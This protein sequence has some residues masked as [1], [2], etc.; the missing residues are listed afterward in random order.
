GFG[1]S[2]TADACT[3]ARIGRADGTATTISTPTPLQAHRWARVWVTWDATTSTI[4]VGQQA[5]ERGQ[6]VGP[7]E[8]ATGSYRG[9]PP[10]AP[11]QGLIGASEIDGWR[12][13]VNAR[14]ARRMLIWRATEAVILIA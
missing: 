9:E 11:A 7:A 12:V 10:A 1:L 5:L 3:L 4:A 8:V 14:M 2:L 13:T 6:S